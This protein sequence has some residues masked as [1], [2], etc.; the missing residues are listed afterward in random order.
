MDTSVCVII[1]LHGVCIQNLHPGCTYSVTVPLIVHNFYNQIILSMI[2]KS[3]LMYIT[4]P[5]VIPRCFINQS[6]L[7]VNSDCLVVTPLLMGPSQALP[8]VIPP[9]AGGAV[10]VVHCRLGGITRQVRWRCNPRLSKLAV[11]TESL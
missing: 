9:P 1:S 8:P 5:R 10:R 3:E 6:F 2:L 4:F 7:V 11:E